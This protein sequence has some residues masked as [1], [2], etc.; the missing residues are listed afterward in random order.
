MFQEH[1]TLALVLE[2]HANYY[3]FDKD[4]NLELSEQRAKS[5]KAFIIKKY[6]FHK[7]RII[8]KAFGDQFPII[9]EQ[10]RD[11]YNNRIEFKLY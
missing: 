6:G 3:L 2:S 11:S 7:S 8:I 1:P 4:K 10:P 9:K 5:F